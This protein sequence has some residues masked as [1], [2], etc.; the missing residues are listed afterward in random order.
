MD[1]TGQV[2]KGM[3]LQSLAAHIQLINEDVVQT[4]FAQPKAVRRLM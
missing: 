1:K 2:F 4:C 3:E